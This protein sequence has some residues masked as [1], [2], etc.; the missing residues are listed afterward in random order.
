MH[1]DNIEE[2]LEE[3]VLRLLSKNGILNTNLQLQQKVFT[4]GKHGTYKI[5]ADLVIKFFNSLLLQRGSSCS[6][7]EMKANFIEIH[8]TYIIVH[9]EIL[10]NLLQKICGRWMGVDCMSTYDQLVFSYVKIS[11]A[12]TRSHLSTAPS[13]AITQL[14]MLVERIAVEYQ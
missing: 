4:F 1:C 5:R 14:L 8:L 13:E 9:C 10:P 7:N 3:F 2:P 6:S 11:P 12:G